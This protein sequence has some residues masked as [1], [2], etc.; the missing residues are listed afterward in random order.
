MTE[1]VGK[2]PQTLSMFCDW[3]ES[4]GW[5]PV[6]NA[7]VKRAEAFEVLLPNVA[8]IGVIDS[9]HPERF[10]D[11]VRGHEINFRETASVNCFAWDRDS[12]EEP[13]LAGAVRGGY[14][15]VR[16]ESQTRAV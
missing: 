16:H 3:L 12:V 5:Q 7:W 4:Q 15:F 10:A 13:A 6:A 2:R 8:I 9:K 11:F 14:R 1:E